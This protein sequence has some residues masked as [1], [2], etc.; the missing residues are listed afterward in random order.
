MRNPLRVRFLCVFVISIVGWGA[1]KGLVRSGVSA[2]ARTVPVASEMKNPAIFGDAASTITVTLSQ[3]Y[4]GVTVTEPLR[5]TAS[6]QNDSSNSGVRWSS[7]GGT[8]SN[9][10]NGSAT[11]TASVAGSYAITA[12]SKA[13]AA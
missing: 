12:T 5:L 1:T 3:V 7:S 8:L 6:V 2:S 4:A 11:F 9:Q 13:D 10:T